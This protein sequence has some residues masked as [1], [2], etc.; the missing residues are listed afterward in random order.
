MVTLWLFCGYSAVFEL[1]SMFFIEIHGMKIHRDFQTQSKHAH[2]IHI[3]CKLSI[4]SS[5][6]K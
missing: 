6:C 4:S 1:H 3:A 2:T 5:D